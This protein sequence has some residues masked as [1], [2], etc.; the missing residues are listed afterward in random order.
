MGFHRLTVPS[1]YGGLPGGYDYI[2]NAVSGTPANANGVL[3]SGPN[4]GITVP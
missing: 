2:N 1:Y 4:T 3:P